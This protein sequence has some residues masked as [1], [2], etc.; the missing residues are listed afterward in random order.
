MRAIAIIVIL[1]LVIGLS[2]TM[3]LAHQ[4][5]QQKISSVKG[6]IGNTVAISPAGFSN[7]SQVNNSLTTSQLSK[8]NSLPHVTSL[9]ETLTDRL[10]TIGSSQPS[11]FGNNQSNSSSN[12]Q[13]SL[14]SPITINVNKNGASG[15]GFRLFF[16]GGSGL[17]ANFNPPVTVIGT[18]NPGQLNVQTGTNTTLS[19]GQFIN[20]SKDADNAMVSTAMASKN[21]LKVGSTFTAYGTTLTVAGIFN[22]S[23]NQADSSTIIVSLPT[24]Q[25]LSGQSGDVTAAVAT[26]DSLDNL[27][28]TTTAIKNVLGSSADVQSAQDQANQAAQP[29][30]SV[31]TI[32]L[33]SLIGAVVAGSIIILLVMV[34]IVRERKREIGVL[35]AIGAGNWR[36]VLQF[37]SEAVTFTVLGAAIGLIIGVAAANPVTNTLVTN[38]A[39]TSNSSA[40]GPGGF[41]TRS[42]IGSGGGSGP[43]TTFR[44]PTGGLFNRGAGNVRNTLRNIS[45]NV[46]WDILLY[47]LGAAIVI[48]LVGSALAAGLIAKVR[49]AEVIRSE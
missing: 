15:G 17:P 32:S 13:T 33:F 28:P 46:G 42:T 6:S 11:F 5:V 12:N 16:S 10:T 19:S 23:S 30:N 48:A 4:A 20:G 8:V 31:K 38:S 14:T 21:N 47:G 40:V 39:N 29:L 18:N 25:R 2:L 36:V 45:A 24:E 35:K 34:M 49:P 3:L 26:V 22:G 27:S 41:V 43:V 7:F 9:T 37:M 44:R 1:G